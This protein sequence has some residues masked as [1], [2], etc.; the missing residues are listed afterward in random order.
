MKIARTLKKFKV[1]YRSRYYPFEGVHCRS[2]GA[3]SAKDIRN[4]WHDIIGTD[5]YVIKKIEEVKE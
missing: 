2:M 4:N 3:E 1:Y 5:E